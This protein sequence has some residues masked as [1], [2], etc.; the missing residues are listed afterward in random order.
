LDR[1]RLDDGEGLAPHQDAVLERARLRLVGVA[2]E[3]MGQSGLRRPRGPLAAGRECGAAATNEP[4]RGDLVDH[5]LGADCAGTL[6]R[7]EATVGAVVVERARVHD[8]DASQ[9]PQ[10]L[11]A[12]L[13]TWGILVF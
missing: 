6:E 3:L 9:E 4:R 1:H 11:V 10:A 12:F 7:S 8:A 5:L 13:W 2:H